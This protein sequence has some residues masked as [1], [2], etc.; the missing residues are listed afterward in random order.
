M[1]IEHRRGVVVLALIAAFMVFVD[2]TIVNLTLAP[3][4]SHLHASRSELE[5]TVNA[6]TLSFAAVMLGAGAITD[7]LGA[8]RAF[9]TGLLVF[10]ASSAVCALASSMLMLDVARLVQGAGA[11]LLLPSALVLATASAADEQER[12]RL[13]GWWVAAGGVGM[14][15]GPPLGGAL[16][17]LVNWR[18]VFAVNVVIGIPAAIWSLRSMPAIARRDR[19]PD[20]AGMGTATVL[21]AGLVFVLIEAP[22]QGWLSPG[23]IAAAAL[24]AAGLVGFVWAERSTRAPLL[25]PGVYSDRRFVTTAA[26][27]AL[28]NFAVFGLLFA[29]GLMLQQGR[30]LSALVS[31]LLFLPLTGLISIGSICAAPLAQRTGRRAVLGIGQAVLATALLAVA[32]AS[33]SSA[34]WPLVL[35]LLPVGLGAGLIVPNLTSQSIAAVEPA[36]HGAASAVFNTS[37]QIGAAI[38]IAAFGPLLGVTHNLRHGFITCVVVGAAATAAALL[39]T[40]L[41]ASHRRRK[42]T[43][44]QCERHVQTSALLRRS[45]RTESVRERSGFRALAPILVFTS[46]VVAVVSSLGA[47]LLPSISAHM[48]VPL[49][50][51]QW[52]L[53]ITLL[54]G[55]ISAPVMGRLGDGPHRR[56]T[57]IA[58]LSAVTLGGVVAALASSLPV[59]V[60]GRGLQGIGLGLVP[61]TMAAARDHFPP[62]RSRPM[63]AL[64]SVVVSAGVGVGYPVSGLIAD[65]LGLSA[66]YWFGA[67]ISGLA[68]LGVVAV[69]PSSK[70]RAAARLDVPGALLLTVGLTAVLLAVA[71]G[72]SWGWASAAGLGL[73]AAAVIA[74]TAWVF[75]E[76]HAR[77][78]LVELRLLCRPTVLTGDV[79][80]VVVGV[81]MYSYLSG[82]SEYVQAPTTTGYGF[83]APVVV[84]GLC[85]L[86]YSVASYAA[87]RALPWFNAHFS[88]R[89]L[90]P[91]GSL[92]VGAAGAFFALFHTSL[93]QAFVMMGVLGVGIGSTF[94]AI[95]GLIVGAVPES[96]TSSALGA[97]QVARYLGYSLGSALTASVLAGHT[98]LGHALPTEGGYTLV[99]WI[100]VAISIAGAALAWIL[101]ARRAR[102]QRERGEDGR[103]PMAKGEPL[104]HR[105][106]PGVMNAPN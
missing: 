72:Q 87:S 43:Q 75:Q 41:T 22:A 63:I 20:I 96:E 18:A 65:T 19:R 68:L 95:P 33:T 36:L 54:V 66:A 77:A 29:M 90:L 35:A 80:T 53:T 71:E 59:L 83:S 12:N 61:V 25:P 23:V 105:T 30:G 15:A 94:A 5:W 92:V 45:D 44:P 32:W 76:L 86:P 88:Q 70:D 40:A 85:L 69:V 13:V 37:R 93:W 58:G 2:A 52:S 42:Y 21:I 1:S 51:A 89:G 60:V 31:G 16:V 98:P 102:V 8:K 64:L 4:A 46:A 55:T 24:T 74:L 73:L 78:P 101:P 99:L 49:S 82:V 100:G 67:A 9:M 17:A 39:L 97:A 10:T 11:A 48:H 47:P 81:V 62:E 27:G 84:A 79:C 56:G 104:P 34:L 28:H 6:Y 7:T 3:L 50:S 26:Q 57:M 106:V 38:G 103:G 14:A 91:V